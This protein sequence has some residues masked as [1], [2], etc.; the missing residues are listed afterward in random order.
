MK[1][2]G[3]VFFTLVFISTSAC[4]AQTVNNKLKR[5]TVISAIRKIQK[6]SVKVNTPHRD[7]AQSDTLRCDKNTTS[8]VIFECNASI[9]TDK[10]Y[11]LTF[12]E[13]GISLE[14]FS[15]G[16]TIYR[17]TYN[18]LSIT[19]TQLKKKINLQRLIRVKPYGEMLCGASSITFSAYK[20]DN[21]YF[22]ADDSGGELNVKGKF[23]ELI[24]YMKG[25]VPDLKTIVDKCVYL[26]QIDSLDV[27][28]LIP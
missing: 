21:C 2:L 15:D 28:S 8:I 6:D 22:T 16:L 26:P 25:L 14:V 19:F 5:N 23:R 24:S 20:G 17:N 11:T 10:P 3:I 12:T 9:A 1:Y 13:D 7:A 27:Y 18:Y 4:H